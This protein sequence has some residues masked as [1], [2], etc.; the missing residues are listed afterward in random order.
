[1]QV[2]F[3]PGMVSG[4]GTTDTMAVSAKWHHHHLC[5]AA[6]L[7]SSSPWM[8]ILVRVPQQDM[9]PPGTEACRQSTG[10]AVME[11]TWKSQQTCLSMSLQTVTHFEKWTT[12]CIDA[13]NTPHS[14][15]KT[16]AAVLTILTARLQSAQLPLQVRSSP[17]IIPELHCMCIQGSPINQQHKLLVLAP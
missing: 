16:P 17:G 4:F 7:Q 1:M 9:K 10:L 15:T 6:L 12:R 3:S 2:S 8:L 11:A 14:G 13:A 5:E